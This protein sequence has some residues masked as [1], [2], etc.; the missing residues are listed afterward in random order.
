[1]GRSAFFVEDPPEERPAGE[2]DGRGE[3][4]D[5]QK[6]DYPTHG[7]TLLAWAPEVQFG[8]SMRWRSILHV[9]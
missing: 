9:A 3:D 4:G 8:L 7:A 6:E 1:M 2:K 5:D